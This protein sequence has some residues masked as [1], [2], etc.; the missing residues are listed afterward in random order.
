MKCLS[1]KLSQNFTGQRLLRF[2]NMCCCCMF[3]RR[4]EGSVQRFPGGGERDTSQLLIRG[5]ASHQTSLVFP[6]LNLRDGNAL[7][8]C[9]DMDLQ[10]RN[11]LSQYSCLFLHLFSS[12]MEVK[13][14]VDLIFLLLTVVSH[15]FL[16]L[17][18]EG[19]VAKSLC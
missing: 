2:E 19:C 8:D 5:G 17:S 11:L 6:H 12:L 7:C 10:N 14:R 3:H 9:G 16:I 13:V 1:V 15:L 4:R 18:P